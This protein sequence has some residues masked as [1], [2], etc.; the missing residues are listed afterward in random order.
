MEE[1][2]TEKAKPDKVNEENSSQDNHIPVKRIKKGKKQ[3]NSQENLENCDKKG[4]K[5]VPVSSTIKKAEPTV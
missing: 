4:K 3:V 2:V 5:I 1:I